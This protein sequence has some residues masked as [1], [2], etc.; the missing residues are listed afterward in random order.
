[1]DNAIIKEINRALGNEEISFNCAKNIMT[2]LSRLTG[3]KYTILNKRVCFKKNG[4]FYDAY[5]YHNAYLYE[6]LS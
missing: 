5:A 6:E 4:K 3:I 1:M 2:Q